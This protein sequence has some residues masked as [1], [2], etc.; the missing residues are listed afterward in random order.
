MNGTNIFTLPSPNAGSYTTLSNYRTN[1]GNYI[2]HHQMNGPNT[3]KVPWPARTDIWC[4]HCCH[5]FDTVPI[6]IPSSVDRKRNEYGVY[7]IFCSFGCAA[8]WLKDRNFPDCAYQRSLLATMANEIFD[9]DEPIRVAPPQD[10]LNVFGGDLDIVAFRNATSSSI[11]SLI[12]DPPFIQNTRV[13]EEHVSNPHE[14]LSIQLASYEDDILMQDT[15]VTA[16]GTIPTG[17]IYSQF[18][19]ARL[20]ERQLNQDNGDGDSSGG[21]SGGGGSGGNIDASS[22]TIHEEGVAP[23]KDSLVNKERIAA[24]KRKR[25]EKVRYSTKKTESHAKRSSPAGNNDTGTLLT[26]MKQHQK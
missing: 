22:E 10:R 9:I 21:G 11:R 20:Q 24:P 23:S 3:S 1:D 2:Y 5:S 7:N 4:K 15:A 6:P 17:G 19:A 25:E 16:S 8:G 13:I 12:R 14:N 18:I 26:F